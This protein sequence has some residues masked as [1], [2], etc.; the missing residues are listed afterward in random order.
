MRY[1]DTNSVV[2]KYDTNA[3]IVYLITETNKLQSIMNISRTIFI[4]I[5]LLV[6]SMMFNADANKLVLEPIE[7]MSEKVKLLATNPL[8][9]MGDD[10]DTVG[11]LALAQMQED[12]A[13]ST[14]KSSEVYETSIIENAIVKIG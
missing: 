10:G 14:K 6:G 8:G 5:L 3:T 13:R 2:S 12:R 9:L 4:M 1:D 7:R 11:I